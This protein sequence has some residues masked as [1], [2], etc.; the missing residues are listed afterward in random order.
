MNE[1][2]NYL[3]NQYKELVPAN[4]RMAIKS[5]VNP[6]PI[7]EANFSKK[8]L[9]TL[10]KIYKNSQARTKNP[11]NAKSKEYIE[12]KLQEKWS[13]QTK[14]Q[15]PQ[16]NSMGIPNNMNN[17]AD[18]ANADSDNAI[19]NLA[20]N[21]GA[22][23]IQYGDYNTNTDI[24]KIGNNSVLRSY[25]GPNYAMATTLGRAIT[26][27]NKI[28]DTY[29]FNKYKGKQT[30][31]PEGKNDALYLFLRNAVLPKYGASMPVDINLRD[32]MEK[33]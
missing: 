25:T 28:T 16:L 14:Y 24:N 18:Y 23:G 5:V 1:I 15:Y 21:I 27:N 6:S 4:A 31:T 13:N 22:K 26:G 30:T 11:I 33:H 17:V 7:T 10:G 9:Q 3:N 2:I 29:D 32:T 12:G 19:Y 8:E 20:Q